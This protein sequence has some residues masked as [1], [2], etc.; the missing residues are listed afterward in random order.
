MIILFVAALVIA[1]AAM[2]VLGVVFLLNTTSLVLARKRAQSSLARLTCTTGILLYL[3][4]FMLI[5]GATSLLALGNMTIF[6][7]HAEEKWLVVTLLATSYAGLAAIIAALCLHI[8]YVHKSTSEN[9]C[10]T[11]TISLPERS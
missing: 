1:Y 11:T 5:V 7:P 2:A 4:L 8:Q 9:S 6:M 3:G 10:A